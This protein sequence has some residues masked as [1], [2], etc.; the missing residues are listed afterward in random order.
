MGT[1]DLAESRPIGALYALSYDRSSASHTWTRLL[2]KVVVSNGLCWT[3]DGLTMYHIDSGGVHGRCVT[4][5]D[6]TNEEGTPRVHRRG[7]VVR[8][9]AKDPRNPS[10]PF[11]IADGCTLDAQGRLWTAHWDGGKV[12]CSDPKTGKVLAIVRVPARR[13]TSVAFGG[14]DLATLFITT[15][16]CETS[17]TGGAIYCIPA[18]LNA[19]GRPVSNRYDGA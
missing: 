14:T 10:E 2:D 6:Y 5:Y 12:S 1:M 9:P 15:A 18:P 7:V 17:G 8:F 11:G 19:R 16:K 3:D 4:A 13:P